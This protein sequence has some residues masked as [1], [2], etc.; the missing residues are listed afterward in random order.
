MQEILV[1]IDMQ[2]DFITG[3]LG[4]KEAKSIVPAVVDKVKNFKGKVFFTKD[5][6]AENYAETQEGKKL[7]VPHCMKGTEGWNI[8]PELEALRKTQPVEKYTFGGVGLA[9]VLTNEFQ[10]EKISKITFVGVCT[11]I[12]VISNVL[13]V[14]AF[15][16]NAT[17]VVDAACCAGTSVK[18]H[19]NAINAMKA[20]QVE[21]ENDPTVKKETIKAE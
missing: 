12:C 20:C 14:K 19:K 15:L 17:L 10:R 13:L 5:T 3:A 1:V 2:N 21:I 4:S 6:H 7:P 9:V 8:I 16:P 18:A 11:D